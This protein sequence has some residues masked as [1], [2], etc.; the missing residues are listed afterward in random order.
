MGIE[1]KSRIE[2]LKKSLYSRNAVDIRTK[3]RANFKHKDFDV[4]TGWDE[5]D[6]ILN[7]VDM[8]KLNDTYE[9]HSMSFFTKLLIAS[10]VFF[11]IA[12]GIGSYIVWNG[13]NIVS[14][15][16]VDIQVT[17]PIN[18]AGGEPVSLNVQ[19]FNK[20]NIKLEVV[21]L[22]M[23]FPD[24]T[25]NPDNVTQE[26]KT[27]RE[28][29]DDIEPGG[30]SQKTVRAAIFGEE[31]SKKTIRVKVE[32]RVKGSNALNYKEKDYEVLVSSSPIS[33][34]VDS[35]K[36]VTSGQEFSVAVT[37]K[38]NSND[39]LKNLVLKGSYPF[40]F[41]YLSSS[42]KPIG[43]DNSS[44]KI[45][46]IPPKSK[47]TVT[48]KGKLD[49]QNEESR[50][51]RFV[52]GAASAKS[53]KDIGTQYIA[54][55]QELKIKKP[56]ISV[57]V[58]LGGNELSQEYVGRFNDP[59]Q[60]EVTWF[61]NLEVPISDAE[62]HVKLSGSAF[63]KAAVS[64]QQGFYKSENNEIIW[65]KVTTRELGSIAA[66]ESGK[67]TFTLTPKDLSSG[68]RSVV[69]PGMNIDVSVSGSRLSESNV[70]QSI[71]SSATRHIKVPSEATLS[72]V[73]VRSFG[74]FENTGPM[75]PQAEKP[76]TYTVI[77]TIYNASGNISNAQV[78]ASLPPYVKWAGRTSPEGEDIRYNAVNG[79][80][81]WNIGSV[82]AYT[83]SGAT[84]K[85]VSF[86]VVLQPSIAQVG[87]ALTLVNDAT[88]AATDD[89]TGIELK[90][91]QP[92]VN[93]NLGTDPAF[94]DGDGAV[95]K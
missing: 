59:I 71:V 51:F 16:N 12:L 1:D 37:I 18:V 83:G 73:A 4:K 57:N 74:P 76:T 32:Y 25:A 13:S 52:A 48:I 43:A 88:M 36:E 9:D 28:L 61:N 46:D 17:G 93:T 7:E 22:S 35:Y 87:Q 90:S 30:M 21:D 24:G 41:T 77:W 23:T 45:G 31:N 81:I 64:P 69:N 49:G 65:N 20:N 44:W 38:S 15:N 11:I 78:A 55:T 94:K 53:D 54:S 6:K 3:R 33:L 91:V 5:P 80:I 14:V 26:L 2:E 42:L 58:A 60:A 10:A 82:G 68:G 79:Q 67:V 47:R 40:G 86:Q 72:G 95:T 75:P 39:V 8:T 92:A 84:K 56:F 27:Y 50:I 89:F 66:G 29:M 85:E 70:P 62:I 19:V 34:T 63:D